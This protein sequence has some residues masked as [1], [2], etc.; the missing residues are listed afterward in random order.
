MRIDGSTT[1]NSL[2]SNIETAINA[3][4]ATTTF[5]NV[6]VTYDATTGLYS[7]IDDV[8]DSDSQ[9]EITGFQ[10]IKGRN[11]GSGTITATYDINVGLTTAGAT[12]TAV[13]SIG[14]GAAQ[15]V[16]LGGTYTLYGPTPSDPTLP[17]S[18]IS[19]TFGTLTSGE[20]TL[21]IIQQE[22]SATLDGGNAVSFQNGDNDVRF[23]NGTAA[24]FS[25][26]E[27]LLVDFGTTVTSGTV[28]I[29]VVNNGLSFHIGANANQRISMNV[30]DIRAT[31]LGDLR[32]TGATVA[33][34]DVTTVTGA[35]EAINI[36]D[37]ALNQV[38][39]QRS[40]LG[41]ISNRLE[42]TINNLSVASENLTA[43]ES[44]I[45]DADMAYETTRFTRN[46]ILIQAGTAIL[47][48]ANIAPQ[49]VLPLLG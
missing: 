32:S 27:I 9:L 25:S 43:S 48:Q 42:S 22:W 28:V 46:Q 29:D 13:V 38:S 21:T 45:R 49:S 34:I 33:D 17:I 37:L 15:T 44:R 12:N 2:A 41:S 36:I 8:G 14:G 7:F 19:I 26:G 20:D 18:Q 23:K 11:G 6:T 4:D 35:N 39:R 47:A 30:G 5:D 1:L 31:N 10:I 24:G 40:S 3:A 16:E